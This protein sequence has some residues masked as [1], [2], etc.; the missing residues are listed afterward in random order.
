MTGT[1][2]G[3]EKQ[4]QAVGK[5]ATVEVES[6]QPVVRRGHAVAEAD[7]RP[8]PAVP[9]PGHRERVPQ[10][11]G[12]A[13]TVA[14][15]RRRRRCQL[16]F[17][18]E[19][20]RKVRVGYVVENPIW[21]T[22]YRLIL[23]EEG[24][25]R[26]CK[27]GPWSRTPR[28]RTGTTSTW[29]WL[30]VGPSPSRWTCTTPLYVNRPVVEPELFASLRPVT[31]SGGM[32]EDRRSPQA[33][34]AWRRIRRQRSRVACAVGGAAGRPGAERARRARPWPARA[35]AQAVWRGRSE[36]PR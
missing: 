32:D 34:R 3:I 33:V 19:G 27:A 23:D 24:A 2:V 28:M 25:S 10:G 14:T 5:D 18:G 31:Y 8:A 12:N 30:P 21:K 16:H 11:P 4:K 13:G 6:A 22:S 26:T 17:T 15:T 35:D 20:K 36:G 1:V 7:R 29:R 9:Q